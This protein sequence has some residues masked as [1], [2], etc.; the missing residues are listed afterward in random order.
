M[1]IKQIEKL[2]MAMRR[3]GT[4]RL[5]LKDEDF[6]IELERESETPE[7]HQELLMQAV[8]E[9]KKE[10]FN[11]PKVD[12]PPKKI[13][14]EKGQLIKSPMVGTFYSSPSPK[15]PAY[16]KVGDVV[17]ENSVVCIIEA[18]KVM[19]EIKAGLSGVVKEIYHES[20]HPVE[21]GTKLFRVG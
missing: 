21:F 19:N 13:V 11:L 4:K 17:D 5:F 10:H 6:E 14:E 1:E 2:M 15:D 7:I 3:F 9:K 16:I 8:Q 18:M 20:G 12:T